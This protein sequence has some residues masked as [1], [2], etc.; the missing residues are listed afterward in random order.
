MTVVKRLANYASQLYTEKAIY[1]A[2]ID[3]NKA[4]V[5]ALRRPIRV[6]TES[7]QTAQSSTKFNALLTTD[8]VS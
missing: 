2:S 6:K 4:S 1:M 3:L 8:A 5:T 7:T